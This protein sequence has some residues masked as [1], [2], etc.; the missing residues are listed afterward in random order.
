MVHKVKAVIA[1]D[2]NA[3][4]SVETIQETDP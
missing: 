4:L 1:K 2:K 3:P